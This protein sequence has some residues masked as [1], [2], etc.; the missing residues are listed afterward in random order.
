VITQ[1]PHLEAENPRLNAGFDRLF[2]SAVR[3]SR[4]TSFIGPCN[5][6]QFR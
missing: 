3:Y 1:V 4:M 2:P 6:N 5:T